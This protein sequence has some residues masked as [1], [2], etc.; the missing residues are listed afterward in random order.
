MWRGGST[1]KLLLSAVL[2][3][4][5]AA[6]LAL[7]PGAASAASTY[8]SV[9]AEI[10]VTV[11]VSGSAA[12]LTPTFSFEITPSS[13]ETVSP[14]SYKV[15]TSGAGTATFTASFDEV[16][17]HHYTIKQVVGSADGWTYD[18][19]TYNVTVYVYNMGSQDADALKTLVTI[20]DSDGYKAESCTF[21]NSYKASTASSKG[22]SADT[23]DNSAD[24]ESGT[25]A[26]ETSTAS[27]TSS[28]TSASSDE[29]E[30]PNTGDNAVVEFALALLAI[31]LAAIT[32]GLVCARRHSEQ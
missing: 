27:Q 21:T 29:A 13:G 12:A 3:V 30:A 1:L 6:C 8:D 32:L 25:A 7:Q 9:T 26:Y 10:P 28:D 31:G 20:E 4:L 18:E 17:E 23:G 19:E 16:G 15:S 11:K 14:G 2:S 5:V 22:S 24:S